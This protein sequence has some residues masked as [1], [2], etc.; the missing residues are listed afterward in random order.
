MFIELSGTTEVVPFHEAPWLNDATTV[1]P[2]KVRK[3]REAPLP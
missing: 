1:V 2:L 3:F